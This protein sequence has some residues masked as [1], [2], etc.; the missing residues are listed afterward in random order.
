MAFKSIFSAFTGSFTGDLG[1][2]SGM[3]SHPLDGTCCG[4]TVEAMA[5]HNKWH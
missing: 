4:T 1:L 2:V 3:N 5:K